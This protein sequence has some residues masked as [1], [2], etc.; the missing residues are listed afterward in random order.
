MLNTVLRNLISNAIKFTQRSG[1]IRI[2][3]IIDDNQV[4]VSVKDSG[5]GISEENI[6]M[7]FRIDSKFQLPGTDKEIG[8]GLGLKLC[9]E[10]VEKQGGKIW[11]ESEEN[12]GCDF[13]FT[14]PVKDY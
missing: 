12:K 8:T 11:V 9:R 6:K 7:L 5:T 14:I 4:T 3:T 10:F 1:N 2:S 13:K